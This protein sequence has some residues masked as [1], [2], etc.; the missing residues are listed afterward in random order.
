MTDDFAFKPV[1]IDFA[2]SSADDTR[3]PAVIKR[4]ITSSTAKHMHRGV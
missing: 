4:L 1:A 2:A 3:P